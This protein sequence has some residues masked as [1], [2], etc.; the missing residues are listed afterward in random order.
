MG[1][2]WLLLWSGGGGGVSATTAPPGP[3][4]P[5][6]PADAFDAACAAAARA[7]GGPPTGSWSAR[8]TLLRASGGGGGGGGGA[9]GGGTA[10]ADAVAVSSGSSKAG[11]PHPP[12]PLAWGPPPA[13]SLPSGP[14]SPTTHV[15]WPASRRVLSGGPGLLPLLAKTAGLAPAGRLE[16]AGLEYGAPGTAA[17]RVGRVLGGQGSSTTRGIVL[18]IE[19]VDVDDLAEAAPALADLTARLKA[20]A[21]VGG[22]GGGGGGGGSGGGPSASLA[23]LAVPV[24]EYALPRAFGPAHGAVQLAALAGAVLGKSGGGGGG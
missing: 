23:P 12:R 21:A 22:S 5:P 17:V 10:A 15:V 19:A 2:S 20:A 7:T 4:N 9:R 1:A 8:M 6:P 24:S 3:A 11:T 18:E 13:P 14:A 16:V